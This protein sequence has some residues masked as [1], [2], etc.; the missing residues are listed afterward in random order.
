MTDTHVGKRY[1]GRTNRTLVMGRGTYVDDVRPGLALVEHDP[2]LPER[3]L[4]EFDHVGL[5]VGAGKR[6]LQ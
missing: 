2:S 3:D 1:T 5:E 6:F 4:Q